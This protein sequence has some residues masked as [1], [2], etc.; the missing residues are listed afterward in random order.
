MDY[1]RKGFE[2][3]KPAVTPKRGTKAIAA[4]VLTQAEAIRKEEPVYSVEQIIFML[5]GLG[6]IE[7]GAI[8]PGTLAR[9]FNRKGMARKQGVSERNHDYGFRRMEAEAPGRL[10]QCDFHH[11]LYLPDP[12]QPEK[13]R[14]AKLCAIL[15]DYSRFI[16]HGQ[17]YWDERMP[18][19]EDTLKKA[20]ENTGFLSSFTATTAPPSVPDTS[21]KSAD[22][23][24]YAFPTANPTNPKAAAKS[25]KFSNSSIAVSSRG[26]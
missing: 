17:Y 21:P 11:T 23:W 3:L 26:S 20:I 14:L 15:D 4:E 8:H 6:A 19:L 2:G 1:R 25:R 18:C 5:E 12:L 16:V 9:H 7:K 13:W 10:W 24:E 22:G